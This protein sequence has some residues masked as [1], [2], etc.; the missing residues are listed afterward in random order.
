[1]IEADSLGPLLLEPIDVLSGIR[2]AVCQ[3]PDMYVTGVK[4]EVAGKSPHTATPLP[5]LHD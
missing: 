2:W 4:L 3:R 5:C 1:M